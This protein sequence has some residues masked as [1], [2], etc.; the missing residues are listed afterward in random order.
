MI[1]ITR[2]LGAPRRPASRRPAARTLAAAVLAAFG[3]AFGAACTDVTVAP[4]SA[5]ASTNVFNDPGAYQAAAAKLYGTLAL[6][7]PGD[8]NNCGGPVPCTDIQGIDAGFGQYL[9]VYWNLQELPTDEATIAWNDQSA[10]VQDLNSQSWTTNNGSITAMYARVMLQATLTSEFLR[11]TT[12]AQLTARGASQQQRAEVARFRAEAR[13]LRAL[14]YWHAMDL[15]GAVPLVTED[16]PVGGRAP[17]QATRQQLH[18]FVVREATAAREGLPAPRR[19]DAS[20]YGR[21]T[22]AASDML[23]AKVFLNAQV[24]TGTPRWSEALQAAQRVIASGAFSLDPQY[25]NLFLADNNRSAE[26]VFAVPQDGARTRTYGGM[27]FLVHAAFGPD[28]GGVQAGRDLGIN[29]GWFGLRARREFG[30]LFTGLTGDVRGNV[31]TGVNAIVFTPEQTLTLTRQID[32]F[33]EGF[34]IHKYRNVTSTGAPGVDNN[35]VD[36]DF[37][38]FRLAD[39]YLMYAEAALRG[40]GGSTGI[41]LGYVNELRTRARAPQV[42]AG[43]LTLPFLID[44]RA[45]EL[46]WEGHRRTDLI[47][48]GQFTGGTKLWQF[49]G[50][51]ANGTATDAR[52]NLYPIPAVELA[53]NP[54]LRQ[55]TGY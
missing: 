42:A 21:A 1:R 15:F 4:Q 31:A 43:D 50:G 32:N 46:F 45:R 17:A 49:K 11:Q 20:Q 7:G 2:P 22:Q 44:E 26:I 6:S 24:Y 52:F 38:M 54:N 29:G 36:V 27:T 16:S 9:R 37:P 33:N 35:F 40:G 30:N 51:A 25:R 12:D 39:A 8:A 10:G 23:L 18:D 3:G 48:F 55:N 34:R 13:F 47:R 41:A 28:A 5:I 53:A 19:G 14:S